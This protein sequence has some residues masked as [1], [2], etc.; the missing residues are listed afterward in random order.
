MNKNAMLLLV[1]MTLAACGSATGNPASPTDISI[2][3]ANSVPQAMG[4]LGT[5]GA[6]NTAPVVIGT[7][8][9]PTELV[10]LDLGLL[11]VGDLIHVDAYALM[12]KGS[13]SGDTL[14]LIRSSDGTNGTGQI[15]F[16][17]DTIDL[18]DRRFVPAGGT[19]Q[20]WLSG[21]G[22]VVT[23]GPTTLTIKSASANSESHSNT[24]QIAI[25]THHM[26]LM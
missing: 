1:N 17:A 14:V 18:E 10:T 21:I 20:V 3:A 24:S 12:T 26:R 7:S 15:F 25:R 2:N 11:Q 9:Y 5:L 23:G 8:A 4:Y 16:S 22:R 6:K 13:L 19:I